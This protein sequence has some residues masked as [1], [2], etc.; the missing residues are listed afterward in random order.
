MYSV[1]YKNA[2]RLTARRTV[3]RDRYAANDV[4]SS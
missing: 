1:M 2:A 4:L 3:A